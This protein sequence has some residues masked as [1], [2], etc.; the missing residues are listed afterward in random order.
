MRHGNRPSVFNLPLEQ[1]QHAA[2]APQYVSETHGHKF[3]LAAM[4]HSLYHHFGQPL[5]SA[6]TLV[7]F[8]ALSVEIST[9]RR[10]LNS[11]AMLAT[12]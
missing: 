5:G 3:S 9:N 1:R 12:L 6:I 7:G 4:A 2:I 8:T 10:T 11:A